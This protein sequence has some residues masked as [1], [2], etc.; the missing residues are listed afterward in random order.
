M[1]LSPWALEARFLASL[2][3]VRQAEDESGR[4]KAVAANPFGAAATQWVKARKDAI[5]AA[6]GTRVRE[7]ISFQVE[8]PASEIDKRP[9]RRRDLSRL[10][11]PRDPHRADF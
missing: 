7:R 3:A 6:E 4:L 2:N 8:L 10:H 1:I 5:T 9:G 11:S